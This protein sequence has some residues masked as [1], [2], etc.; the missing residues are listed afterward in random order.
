MKATLRV[1]L[2]QYAFIEF[3]YDDKFIQPADL[4]AK[5]REAMREFKGGPGLTEREFQAFI[6]RQLCGD[7]NQA[8]EY[9]RTSNE[10]KNVIQIIKR[11][12]K[13]IEAR[14]AKNV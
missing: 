9:A 2:D 5:Y 6:D 14:Q 8:D 3:R 13:R 10:Q 11:A 12:L 4:I 7:P 1:P